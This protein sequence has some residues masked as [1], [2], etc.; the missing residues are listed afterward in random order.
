MANNAISVGYWLGH[1]NLIVSLPSEGRKE[2]QYVLLFSYPSTIFF[3]TCFFLGG[4]KD[5]FL[6]GLTVFCF[7]PKKIMPAGG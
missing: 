1:A 6:E 4:R 3:S 7:Q 5:Q 2:K